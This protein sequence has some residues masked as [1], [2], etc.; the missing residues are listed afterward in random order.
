MRLGLRNRPG[1]PAA[2]PDH[3]DRQYIARSVP[4][5]PGR[6]PAS[7][8]ADPVAGGV[9]GVTNGFP[10]VRDREDVPVHAPADMG[11]LGLHIPHQVS[12]RIILVVRRRLVL[13]IAVPRRGY[14]IPDARQLVNLSGVGQRQ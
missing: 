2:I 7:R 8:L 9:I 12:D 5:I 11:D 4:H 3:I 13:Y 1:V 6:D 10:R 14:R